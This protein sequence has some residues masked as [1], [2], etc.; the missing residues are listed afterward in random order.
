MD[1][2]DRLRKKE[3]GAPATRRLVV[4]GLGELYVST[5][6]GE[7][8]ITYALGSCLGVAVHDPV[9]R[10]GGML[11]AV[12]PRIE[13]DPL[14]ARTEPAVF[15][16]SGLP[17]LF[18]ACYARGARKERLV[19]RIAGAGTS[20]DVERDHFEIGRRNLLIARQ[21][22]W[23]NGVLVSAQD[24]GGTASRTLSLHVGSG[25]VK[26]RSAGGGSI[27]L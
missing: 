9:A 24:V 6:P 1:V 23:K 17:A 15:V 22:F 16:E 18:R 21:L 14:R 20:A 7:T 19:V 26:V 4:V 11:H 5:E 27:H 2:E 8:L 3:R 12:H 25:A 10:V 13:L